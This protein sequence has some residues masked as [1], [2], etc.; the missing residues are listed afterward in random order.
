M[1][2]IVRNSKL[3]KFQWWRVRC[4]VIDKD[5]K[6]QL[7]WRKQTTC[8]T[9]RGYPEEKEIRAEPKKDESVQE[10]SARREGDVF[11]RYRLLEVTF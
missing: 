9:N 10:E 2:T 8:H 7:E 3:F 11:K 5:Y 1:P 6:V 4:S